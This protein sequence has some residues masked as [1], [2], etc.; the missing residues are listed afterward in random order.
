[1]VIKILLKKGANFKT[2]IDHCLS[3]FD[4]SILNLNL[5]QNSG[6]E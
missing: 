4:E 2:Q 6:I 3:C 1:M 5:R